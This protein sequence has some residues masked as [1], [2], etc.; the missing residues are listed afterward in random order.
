[1]NE[2]TYKPIGVIHSPFKK[3]QGTPIQPSA[4]QGV[5]GSVEVF[6]E[7]VEGLRDLDGFSHIILIYHFHLAK[8][9]SLT[10]QPF[11]DDRLH[12]IFAV[13]APSRP[14]PIGLSVVRLVKIEENILHVEDLDIL[15]GTPLLDIKPYVPDFDPSQVERT[16]W[17]E[18]NVHKLPASRDDGRFSK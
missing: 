13:R 4:A 8:S 9:P 16:G 10:V 17:F 12:G 15:D 1:V 3:P 14:N 2:I 11:M 5:K 18:N 7:Y 6:S